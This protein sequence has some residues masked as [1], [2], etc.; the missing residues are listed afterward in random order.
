MFYAELPCSSCDYNQPFFTV[1]Q[2]RAGQFNSNRPSS[3]TIVH[4]SV[5]TDWERNRKG[6]RNPS[7]TVPS[8]EYAKEL[9]RESSTATCYDALSLRISERE[10][11][12]QEGDAETAD[13]KKKDSERSYLLTHTHTQRPTQMH[14]TNGS[15]KVDRQGNNCTIRTCDTRPAT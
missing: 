6:T 13:K 15:T 4:H 1:G 11:T 5:A 10:G 7:I 9:V 14:S 8:L 12:I 2:G 3:E